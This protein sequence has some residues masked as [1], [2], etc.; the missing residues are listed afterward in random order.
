MTNIAIFASGRGSNAQAILEYLKGH[1][2][3]SVKLILS[4]KK[5]AGVLLL[6]DEYHIEKFVFNK[7]QF[8]SEDIV[9]Q[10]L[11]SLNIEVLVLAGFL[12]KIPSYLIQA[13]P[14]RIINIHPS[15]LPKYGG[16]GMYGRHV[17]EAV[18]KNKDLESGITIHLVNEVYDDGKILFQASKE[19]EPTDEP[20]VIASKVLELEHFYFPRVIEAFIE[21]A[22][23]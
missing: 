21:N 3:I 19:L 22:E 4:N 5:D 13:Y 17:H 11:K 9:L 10:K 16:K 7:S 6:A 20:S 14:E 1:E 15:L 8:N 2:E 23:D 12:W 18:Y